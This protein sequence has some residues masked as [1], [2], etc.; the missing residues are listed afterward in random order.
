MRRRAA[1]TAFI[2]NGCFFCLLQQ[3]S[4]ARR[5]LMRRLR[6]WGGF[7]DHT[8]PKWCLRRTVTMIRWTAL[9]ARY[10]ERPLDL[11]S[12]PFPLLIG[13]R[14]RLGAAKPVENTQRRQREQ[15]T[16]RV[17]QAPE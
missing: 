11:L 5:Y 12:I 9:T 17:D 13:R 14:L 15:I 8:G 16:N 7:W 3:E 2:P 4:L 1:G 10:W 6:Y